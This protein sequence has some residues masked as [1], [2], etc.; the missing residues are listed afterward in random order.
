MAIG[1]LI[2]L[3]MKIDALR[4]DSTVWP[5]RSSGFNVLTYPVTA[6]APMYLLELWFTLT[7]SVLNFLVWTG[8]FLFRPKK[9]TFEAN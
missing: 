1:S 6:L 7:V 3:V 2:G 8:I 4:D 9:E 5:R